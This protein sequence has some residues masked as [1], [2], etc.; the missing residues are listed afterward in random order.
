MFSPLLSQKRSSAR[1]RIACAAGVTLAALGL[2]STQA[3]ASESTPATCSGE[4]FS[5]PFTE[6]GDVNLYT[7]APGGEFNSA[8]EGWKL[9]GGASIV[10]TT[11]PNGKTGGTLNLPAGAS[12]TSPQMCVTREY[13]IA[14][15]WTLAASTT[16]RIKVFVSYQGT[17]SETEPQIVGSLKRGTNTWMLSEFRLDPKLA[18]KEEVPHYVNFVFEAGAK[19]GE[20]QLYDLYVDPRM[21]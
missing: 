20:T 8:S 18:G 3:L 12:A 1:R 4:T 16:K 14:K 5:Q 9:S 17:R 7:L 2:S 11:R 15:V 21:R 6:F 10:T 13:P 19:T